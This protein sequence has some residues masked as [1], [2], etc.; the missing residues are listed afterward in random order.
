[1]IRPSPLLAVFAPLVLLLAGSPLRAEPVQWSYTGEVQTTGPGYFT[2]EPKGKVLVAAMLRE[3]GA[4][5]FVVWA[6]ENRRAEFAD[7]GGQGSGSASVTAFRLRAYA[8]DDD[9]G[10]LFLVAFNRD[11]ETF[12]L[13]L[14]LTDAA[15]GASGSV[16]VKGSLH[17]TVER[18][19]AK[20]ALGYAGPTMQTLELGKHLYKVS[21]EPGQFFGLVGPDRYTP[22]QDFGVRVD[23]TE[24]PEPS[25]LALAALGLVGAGLGAWRRSRRHAS[26][27]V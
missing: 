16:A 20:L 24:A 3:E 11:L 2:I 12:G 25:A 18:G 19:G 22:F 15:S 23:V 8:T 21:V 26:V 9:G 17:G 27:A 5:K 14:R 7:A 4:G 13:T 6:N 1:M 10:P